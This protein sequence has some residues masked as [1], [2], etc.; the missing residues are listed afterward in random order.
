[1]ST[2]V[3]TCRR[4][5]ALALLACTVACTD[6]ATRVAY[7]LESGAKRL[8]ASSEQSLTVDHAPA[9]KP[10]GCSRGYTLQLSEAAGLLVW[11][12]DS[13]HGPSSS[14]HITTYHL[15]YVKVPQTFIIH[16]GPGEHAYIELT[17]HGNDIDVT[18][19]H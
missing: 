10:E 3:R 12:Q 14:S 8:R 7:D 2:S 1:M 15:N 4:A 19:L 17:K 13:L 18:A 5:I 9:Q 6:A 11:C 16:K